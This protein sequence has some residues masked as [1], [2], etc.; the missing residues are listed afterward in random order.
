VIVGT[1]LCLGDSLT[2]GA[3]AP[4]GLGYPEHLV[5]LLD[6]RSTGTRWASLN[7]GV[8]GEVT[9][10]IL[11]RT[12][13]AVRELAGLFGAK[14]CVILAGTN[15]AKGGGDGAVGVERWSRL[16]R[17]LVHWPLRYGVPTWLCTFPPV[18]PEMP[19]FCKESGI[20]LRNASAVVRAVQRE[21][22]GAPGPDGRPV[23]VKLVD[24]E[25]GLG[26]DC[27]VD[28]VHLTAAGYSQVA[29]LVAGA[30]LPEG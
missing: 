14:G 8:S 18:G 6:E 19:E 16:Y 9:W 15:D 26:K 1:V 12:P 7:R 29:E 10:E 24:L 20:W 13:G 4:S 2:D 23:P 30:I 11:R 17:Q 22:H 27:L 3:R 5:E 28:G 25:V 21:L